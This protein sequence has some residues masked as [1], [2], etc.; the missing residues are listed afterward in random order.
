VALGEW[1]W[2]KHVRQ[3]IEIAVSWVAD[4]PM[5]P[6]SWPSRSASPWKMLTVTPSSWPMVAERA[7]LLV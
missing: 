7:E 1:C 2:I 3:I 5:S 4:G 6:V